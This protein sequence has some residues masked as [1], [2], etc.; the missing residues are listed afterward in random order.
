MKDSLGLYYHPYPQNKKV[1]VYVREGEGTIWFRMWNKDVT[2]LWQE[3]GWVPYGAI[4]KAVDIYEGKK[5][6]DPEQVYDLEI[7]KTLLKLG[8]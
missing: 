6:F 1:R 2:A 8:E 5:D 3:H 7:A 4:K